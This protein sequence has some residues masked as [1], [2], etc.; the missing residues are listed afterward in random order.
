MIPFA[1]PFRLGSRRLVTG[2]VAALAVALA[3]CS[4]SP[5]ARNPQPAVAVSAPKPTPDSRGIVTYPNYQIVIARADDTVATI[6]ERIGI[7]AEE[8]ARYNGLPIDYRTRQGEVLVLPRKVAEDTGTADVSEIERIA[9]TALEKAGDQP[10]PTGAPPSAE[11]IRHRVERGETA[12][13]IAR[14]YGVSP[15][16]LAEWNGL[17]PDLEV[18]EGQILVIPLPARSE[19]VAVETIDTAP[20]GQGSL[21]PLPPS[22]TKPLPRPVM[23]PKDAASPA[24]RAAPAPSARPKPAPKPAAPADDGKFVMP[25]QGKILRGFDKAK[26]EGIDIAAATGT[27]VRAAADGEVAAITRDTEGV[28]ILVVRHAGGLLTV[29]ANLGSI[30][31]KKGQTV[32]RGQTIATVGGGSPSFLHFEVRNGFESVDPMKFF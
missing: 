9:T 26:N 5:Y 28:P 3:G 17:G 2:S 8:L 30:S 23:R 19:I 7:P 31:V 13:S 25:V 20:P 18:R 1:H 32:K 14:L 27:P 16:A 29:Y 15:R 4:T 22:S 21:T 11:P 6:A 10:P 24:K 12:Y